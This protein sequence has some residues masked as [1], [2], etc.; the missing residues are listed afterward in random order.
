MADFTTIKVQVNTGASDASPTW[1]DVGFGTANN[2]LRMGPGN[3][4]TASAAWGSILK[5]S[6]GTT[7]ITQM[8]AYTTDNGAGGTGNQVTT[9][10]G[11]GSHYNQWRINWDNTGTFGDGPEIHMYKDNTYPAASPGSQPGTGDGSS[12]VNGTSGES[13]SRSLYKC[14]MFGNGRT[15]AGVADNPGS[16]MGSNPTATSGGAGVTTTSNAT[17][18]AWTDLQ[19]DTNYIKNGAT[20]AATTAGTWNGLDAEYIAAGMTGGTLLPVKA[21]RYTWI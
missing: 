20:P 14:A 11:T 9:Y 5:P 18:T 6:S 4:T 17:W 3:G 16:N 12:I 19:A 10:D 13:S 1:T 7:L 2:E 8:W 15:A 21:F